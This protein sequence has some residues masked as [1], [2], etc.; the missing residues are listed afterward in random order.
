MCEKGNIEVLKIQRL[1][2]RFRIK[3]KRGQKLKED[4]KISESYY[5]AIEEFEKITQVKEIA[6]FR[7]AELIM[8]K[9]LLVLGDES[10]VIRYLQWF[11]K[12][13]VNG[14]FDLKTQAEVIKFQ[15]KKLIAAD[16]IVGKET[17]G[18]IIE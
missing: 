3:D 17:W 2:N 12:I 5:F 16:G 15:S 14:K 11:L 7:V 1:L 8:S 13:N 4:G 10:F 18:K 6:T 9:P